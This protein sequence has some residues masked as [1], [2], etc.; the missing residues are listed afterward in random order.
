[1]GPNHQRRWYNIIGYVSTLRCCVQGPQMTPIP[2]NGRK[3]TGRRVS[4]SSAA[5]Y[6]RLEK[7]PPGPEKWRFRSLSQRNI[8]TLCACVFVRSNMVLQSVAPS[9]R[10]SQGRNFGAHPDCIQEAIKKIDLSGEARGIFT[11]CSVHQLRLKCM[12]CIPAVA[13]HA[14]VQQPTQDQPCI[15]LVAMAYGRTASIYTSIYS[16]LLHN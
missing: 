5:R 1:M 16:R 3:Y 8:L 12:G 11:G 14:F 7:K 9:C 13:I 6:A 10:M 2:R 4:A 15:S